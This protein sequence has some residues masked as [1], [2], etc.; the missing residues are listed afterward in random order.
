MPVAGFH[1]VSVAD[2]AKRCLPMLAV[3]RGPLVRKIDDV[4]VDNQTLHPIV[5]SDIWPII[6]PQHG[7]IT[8]I[9][10]LCPHLR[11]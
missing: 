9:L 7:Q 3:R 11:C 2:D 4:A 8:P 5:C 10:L 1:V 6:D